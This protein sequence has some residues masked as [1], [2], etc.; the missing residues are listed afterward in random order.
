MS[1]A[2]IRGRRRRRLRSAASR[3]TFTTSTSPQRLPLLSLRASVALLFLGFGGGDWDRGGGGSLCWRPGLR[4]A[5]GEAVD[6]SVDL[7]AELIGFVTPPTVVAGYPVISVQVQY[8]TAAAP[9]DVVLN[10]MVK[11]VSDEDGSMTNVRLATPRLD[12]P[13]K[14]CIHHRTPTALLINATRGL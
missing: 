13:P 10:L 8:Q 9:A 11:R 4:L 7:P 5:A 2:K 14:F 1:E 3:P 6:P 12:T